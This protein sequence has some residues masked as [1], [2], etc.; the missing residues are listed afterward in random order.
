MREKRHPILLMCQVLLRDSFT[1][2]SAYQILKAFI[3]PF[4]MCKDLYGLLA[5]CLGLPHLRALD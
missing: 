3:V 2:R 4:V 5:L 1:D